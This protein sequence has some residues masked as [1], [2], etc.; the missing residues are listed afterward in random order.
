HYFI[1]VGDLIMI[2]NLLIAI[3][4]SLLLHIPGQS[5]AQTAEELNQ[6][7]MQLLVD[8][9]L[10]EAIAEFKKAIKTDSTYVNAYINLGFIYY[11][12]GLLDNAV[13]LYY[14][15]LEIK[16]DNP[17]AHN[18]LGAALLAAGKPSEAIIEYKVAMKLNPDYPEAHNNLAFAYYSVGLYDQAITEAQK[19][20]EIKPNYVMAYN[21]LGIS[22]HMKGM[23]E[24]AI[25]NFNKAL[26]IKP[27]FVEVINNLGT[28]YRIKGMLDKSIELHLSA[29]KLDSTNSDTFNN[30][31][32][33]YLSKGLTHEAIAA[34]EKVLKIAPRNPIAHNNLS[35]AYYDVL[36]YGLAM[37]HAKAAE[38]FGIK[39]NAE[40]YSDLEKSLDPKY[41]RVRHILVTK[42]S[43]A[44]SIVKEL[45]KGT[46]FADLASQKSIDVNTASKG[47]D[48]GYFQKGDLQ[49]EYEK[50]I[51]TLKVGE[52]SKI[53]KTENGYHIFKRLK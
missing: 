6:T 26:E 25:A 10:N 27:T 35:Y 28:T 12:S 5:F 34:F 40:F 29:A 49:A 41:M 22:Y 4:N 44:D 21:Y 3:S 16:P 53:V 42:Q 48:L 47:G 23:Y 39:I 43:E 7:A 9:K 14:K 20:L 24:E 17:L 30:L 2:K 51:E 15:A 52:I 31:G 19:A 1:K 18:N 33:A 38:R 37:Q 13:A 11:S 46:N 8:G 45:Q 50:A 36:N 32:L